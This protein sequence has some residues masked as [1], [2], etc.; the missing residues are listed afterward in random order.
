M[1]VWLDQVRDPQGH[2]LKDLWRAEQGISGVRVFLW[3][4]CAFTLGWKQPTPEWLK[5]A[6]RAIAILRRPTAGGLACHGTDVSY[7]LVRPCSSSEPIQNLM[8]KV[9]ESTKALCRAFGV[10]AEYAVDVA[11]SRRIAVC[12]AEPSSYAVLVQGRKLAGFAV[13]RIA[14]N[15]LIQGSLLVSPLPESL[16]RWMPLD[17]RRRFEEQA[18]S[19]CEAAGRGLDQKD[20]AGRWVVESKKFITE[21]VL[22]RAGV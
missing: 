21:R 5:H 10:D 2:M 17:L 15:W 14:G 19:L 22:S 6:S 1:R 9:C 13:R 4:P 16:S 3:E 11:S 12:L 8:Q 7:A 20:V 18:I